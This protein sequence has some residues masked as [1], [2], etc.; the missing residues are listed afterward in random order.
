LGQALSNYTLRGGSS[1]DPAF[2]AEC[3]KL[4]PKRFADT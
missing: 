4:D 2:R 3:A 1:Y